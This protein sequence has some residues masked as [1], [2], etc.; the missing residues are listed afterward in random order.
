MSEAK[1]SKRQ[2]EGEEDKPSGLPQAV[3]AP[4]RRLSL[5]WII[6]LLAV[7]LAAWL[8]FAAWRE[9]GIVITVQLPEG[10]GLRIGDELRYRGINVGEVREVELAEDLDGVIVTI[11][12]RAEADLLARA[13]SRFWVV[14]PQLGL[15]GVEG[16]ETLV[17]PR[18]LSVLPG[19]D[20]ARGQR[21]F[22]GLS[23]PPPVDRIEPGD[24]EIILEAESR[25]SLRPCAPVTYRQVRVG[26]V[27][28]AGLAS[29]GSI[30]EARLHIR[31]A[32]RELIRQ[33]TQFWD[34]GGVRADI[35][36]TG[37]SV[38][39][40]SIEDLLAGGVA[41]ATPPL[42]DAGE[43]V[44]TGHRFRLNEEP[45]EDWL[46]WQP[47]VAVGSSLLPPGSV[48]PQPLRAVIGWK[49]GFIFKG[50]KSRQGW[51]LQ[52]DAGLLGPA[53]LLKPDEDAEEE[54]ATLEVG[55]MVMPLEQ[56]PSWE[57]S[58]L[59]RLEVEI[60]SLSWSARRMRVLA[61]P[62]DCIILADRAAAALPLAATRLTPGEGG[63]LVDAA[64]SVDESWH[65]A[66]VLSRA[67]GYLVGILLV[68][69]DEAVVA[70]VVV[71]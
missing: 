17:G 60:T 42:E 10:H 23:S 41:L 30:V 52:T 21:S 50:K 8:G 27:M 61:E 1:E 54:T 25:G 39:L 13:G 24:L 57:G 29:D 40:D 32:Y 11:S 9:R 48:L 12:L 44:H 2:D 69:E 43:I 49:E 51:V 67:D 68:G 19:E 3:I 14:R 66:C 18:Y 22:V 70:P 28:S 45:D 33:E 47:T 31:K 56:N 16:L 20:R 38:E 46:E 7:L 62:E 4:E 63:W 15:T 36:L 53:D 37:M 34:A 64:L 5:A 59:A 35:G 71:E 26:T 65:G 6:P 58:G 55:G